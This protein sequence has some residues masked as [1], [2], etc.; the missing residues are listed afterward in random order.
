MLFAKSSPEKLD[1]LQNLHSHHR[2]IKSNRRHS[3][4]SPSTQN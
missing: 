1:E 4:S 3:T 2:Q